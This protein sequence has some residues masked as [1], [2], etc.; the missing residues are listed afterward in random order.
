MAGVDLL[1]WNHVGIR[2]ADRGR[3]VAFYRLLGFEEIGWAEGPRVSFLRNSAGVELNLIVN[4]DARDGRNVL[5]DEPTKHPGYTHASFRV[6]S[7]EDTAAALR[8]AGIAIT[9]GP[10]DL[11]GEIAV[12]VR[13]PDQN[14]IEL[15]QLTRR[16]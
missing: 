11:G 13:D 6:A 3:S 10:V 9:E 12:F 2:V 7:A 16:G 4:A 15:A 8:A 14:V 5:M 1:G